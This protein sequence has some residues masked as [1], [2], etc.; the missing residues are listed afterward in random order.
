MNTQSITC[1]VALHSEK[2][3]FSEQASGLEIMLKRCIYT[4]KCWGVRVFSIQLKIL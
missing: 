1:M 4:P 3:P 2:L